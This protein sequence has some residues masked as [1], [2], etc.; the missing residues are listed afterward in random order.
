LLSHTIKS[1]LG[2]AGRSELLAGWLLPAM[3]EIERQRNRHRQ[4]LIQVAVAE[5][6]PDLTVRRGPF[7]GMRYPRAEAFGSVL[8]P[9]LLGTYELELHEVLED[10]VANKPTG[11]VDIGCAEGYYAV[12]LALRLPSTRVYA[13]DIDPFARAACVAMAEENAV[14]E[15]V[16]AG[17]HCGRSELRE[18]PLG[19]RG[20]VISD[21]EGAERWLFDPPTLLALRDHD[22]IIEIHDFVYPDTGDLLMARLGATHTVDRIDAITEEQRASSLDYEELSGLSPADRL[23]LVRE[24][25]P[26]GMYWLVCRPRQDAAASDRP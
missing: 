20:L 8:F 9:K 25:R 19:D 13:F 6:I 2:W 15:S 3:R 7:R 17:E 23:D 14:S 12:G 24:R 22:L 21:C 18:L 11:I 1:L 16:V 10:L 5:R 26:P 4:A